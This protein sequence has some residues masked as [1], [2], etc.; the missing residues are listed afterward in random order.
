MV[1]QGFSIF[2]LVQSLRGRSEL[3]LQQ[4]EGFVDFM[5]A[6]WKHHL[7]SCRI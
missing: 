1:D 5:S 2:V 7:C 4:N 3:K 6:D